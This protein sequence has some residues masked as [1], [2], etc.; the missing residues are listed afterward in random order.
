MTCS[1]SV[2]ILLPRLSGNINMRWTIPLISF[3]KALCHDSWFIFAWSN[4]D[5]ACAI[6]SINMSHLLTD[7]LPLTAA[8]RAVINA[9]FHSSEG[10]KGKK[11]QDSEQR[12][13]VLTFLHSS[14]SL[15]ISRSSSGLSPE[16]SNSSPT[17]SSRISSAGRGRRRW[18]L[19]EEALRIFFKFLRL[20]KIQVRRWRTN[21]GCNPPDCD[22]DSC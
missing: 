3:Q 11:T 14:V 7:R 16:L 5:L 17:P 9:Y 4:T 2:L 10:T 6:M 1:V 21:P 19:G 18:G 8:Q 22:D 15:K 13:S 20:I 12:R